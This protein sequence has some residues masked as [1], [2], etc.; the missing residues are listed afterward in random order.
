MSWAA[1]ADPEA[2]E[3]A[4]VAEFGPRQRRVLSPERKALREHGRVVGSAFCLTKAAAEGFW[5]CSGCGEL[6]HRD[7]RPEVCER[8]QEARAVWQW[9]WFEAV[10]Q[11]SATAGGGR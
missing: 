1:H 9:K 11:G 7:G 10:P 6:H 8:C 3:A 2:A 4:A 5:Q